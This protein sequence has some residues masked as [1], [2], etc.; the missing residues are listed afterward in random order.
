MEAVTSG[1]GTLELV[2]DALVNVWF[3][4]LTVCSNDNVGDPGDV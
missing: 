3:P 2:V 1:D 4:T